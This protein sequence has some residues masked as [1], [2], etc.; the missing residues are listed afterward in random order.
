MGQ[1]VNCDLGD[2]AAKTIIS[3]PL[4]WPGSRCQNIACDAAGCFSW[5]KLGIFEVQMHIRAFLVSCRKNPSGP[6]CFT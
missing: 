6:Q 2:A 4:Y 1:I 5:M 3:E